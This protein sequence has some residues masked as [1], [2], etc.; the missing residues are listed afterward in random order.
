MKI[1]RILSLV[2]SILCL[3]AIFIP[4]ASAATQNS[5]I[6]TSK[7]GSLT[8]YKYEMNDTSTATNKAYGETSDASGVPSG[9]TPLADVTFKITKVAEVSSKYYLKDGVALPTAAQ[10]AAMSPIK[11]YTKTTDGSGYVKFDALP[12]G[13]YLV[14]ETSGPSQITGKVA[15]FVVSVPTTSKDGAKWNYDV[16]VYPKNKTSYATITIN[17][18]DYKNG[19][20]VAGAKF[21]LEQYYNNAWKTL[22]TGITTGSTGTVTP[23]TK[24]PYGGTF[25][26]V[27][28][29]APETYILDHTNKTTEF[30]IDYSG[31]TCN[32]TTK[33]VLDT[34][35]P[36]T[37]SIKNTKPDIEKFIDKSEGEGTDLVK[38]TTVNHTSATDFDYYVVKVSTPN[39]EMKNMSKFTVTD[40]VK[41][42][43]SG[44]VSVLK[45]IDSANKTVANTKT[46]GGYLATVQQNGTTA[47]VTV[48]F[49][50][51]NNTVLAKN[52]DYFI[53]IKCKIS[54]TAGTVTDNKAKLTYTHDTEVKSEDNIDSDQTDIAT[55]G[56]EAKKVNENGTALAGAEFK[57]Y[58]TLDDANTGSNAVTVYDVNTN[59]FVTKFSSNANGLIRIRDIY[60]GDDIENDSKD[61]YLVETKAPSADY[62]LL[63]APLKITVNKN[64]GSLANT[65]MTIKN[66]RKTALP[67]TGGDGAYIWSIIGVICVSAAAGVFFLSKKLSK[68]GSNKA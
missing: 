51:D 17:K 65:N 10:A 36:T 61:Y 22:A 3:S 26:L 31:R 16:T 52:T 23:T 40:S 29:A 13:L 27:E 59:S 47:T 38:Q 2:L 18:T 5:V 24:L 9:A 25:R 63:S 1:K 44:S 50:T 46:S 66:S 30:Y 56:Y 60:Y 4:T 33:A 67:P 43:L 12:L 55:A 64:S 14:Q 49:S 57:L 19:Q 68:K 21:T 45:V 8:L 32:A 11:T 15:D 37:V 54:A 6:D 42:V 58:K 7:T 28:T 53:Y 41:N 39:V 20:A 62:N 35:N 48:D 34:A